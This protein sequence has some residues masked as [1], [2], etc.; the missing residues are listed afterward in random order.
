[1]VCTKLGVTGTGSKHMVGGFLLCVVLWHNYG[2]A[3]KLGVA[4]ETNTK[5]QGLMSP[6]K[7]NVAHTIHSS[8]PSIV[9]ELLLKGFLFHKGLMK[10]AVFKLFQASP[11]S[12]AYTTGVL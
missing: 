9:S 3:H 2:C 5:V 10:I 11:A 7:S 12:L 4:G 6:G 1:M 8:L